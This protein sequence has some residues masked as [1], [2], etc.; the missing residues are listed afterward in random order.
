[1]R[2]LVLLHDTHLSPALFDISHED[3]TIDS[4]SLLAVD[5]VYIPRILKIAQTCVSEIGPTYFQYRER[6]LL[7]ALGCY[8]CIPDIG[9]SKTTLDCS[10]NA[11]LLW[12]ATSRY[13]FI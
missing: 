12:A 9:P 6:Y 4:R 10:Q 11:N 7:K 2:L 5:V 13:S 8:L 3:L 1:M